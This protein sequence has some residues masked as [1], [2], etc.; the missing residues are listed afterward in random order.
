MK[1]LFKNGT[2]IDGSGNPPFQ[3]DLLIEDDRIVQVGG[4]IEESVIGADG[5]VVDCTGLQVCP[6]LIDAH[7]HNDFF[8]D[9]EDADLYYRPFIEQ[10]ITTQVTG[11]C[12]FSPFGAIPGSEYNSLIG[13]GLF[14]ALHPG[15]YAEFKERAKGRLYVNMAPLI[16]HGTCRTTISGFKSDPLSDEQIDQIKALVDEAM[17]GGAFGGSFGF[18]Y[19]PGI[20]SER[21]EIDAFA[22]E[23]AKYGGI[24][25][26]HPRACSKIGPGYPLITKK[27]HIELALDEVVDIMEKSG[28]RMEYSHLI[29]TGEK[30]WPSLEPM[31]KQ[32]H[33]LHD[34]Q[35]KPIAFDNYS[36]EYGASVITVALPPWYLDM[37]TEDRKKPLNRFKIKT[38][39]NLEKRLLGI[40]WSDFIIAYISDDHREYEGRIIADVA[41]ER[42]MDP[43]DLYLELVELSK[44]EG[45]IY[46]GKY[47]NEDIIHR[48]MEDDLSIFMTDAWVEESGT[49][50]ISAF[51]CF[52]QFF[53]LAKK[54]G[55]PPERIVRKMTGATVDRFL[56]KDRGYLREGYKADLTILDLD[57][58][59]VNVKQQNF[60]P[61]G[62]IHVYVNG[63]PELID[64]QFVNNC[65]GEVLSLK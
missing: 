35:N 5:K 63:Q 44:G 24:I 51:Q 36:F 33:D 45:R 7:S 11:N 65:A 17:E 40:D 32:F 56:I 2:L 57:H 26:V 60:K 21:K 28:C 20:F 55:I 29:F 25:T 14:H 30:S 4:E 53:V 16:G 61:E 42:K 10:G 54:Y 23:V 62:I 48:L 27:P 41:E 58:M 19:E 47:Y 49:Q 22:K 50:N 9:R 1:T 64:T 8:Y 34:K 12:S 6:G 52:P 3:G 38:Y 37:T 46:L 31:L 43:R 59:K 18:M 15:T 13:G 39:L